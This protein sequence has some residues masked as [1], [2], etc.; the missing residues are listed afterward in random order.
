MPSRSHDAIVKDRLCHDRAW[1]PG[2]RGSPVYAMVQKVDHDVCHDRSPG[3]KEGRSYRSAG[4][5]V[6]IGGMNCS[7]Q[8]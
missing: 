6:G 5:T 8:R 3:S 1:S 2:R 4:R 7:L